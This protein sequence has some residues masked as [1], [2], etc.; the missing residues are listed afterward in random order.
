MASINEINLSKEQILD[1]Y[2]NSV[3]FGGAA[4]YLKI[5]WRSFKKQAIKLG[6]YETTKRANR[7]ANKYLLKD[8]LEGKHPQYPTSK[9]SKRLVKEG[10]KKYK[11][12][13]CFISEWNKEKI[14]LELNHIDGDS[15]NHK[16]NNLELLCP[17]CHSQTATYRSKK[18]TF[19][20]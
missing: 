8:I 10:I 17:N 7:T 3:G 18:L 12:E 16:V 11:C 19:K 4:R 2:A 13:K 14:S 20:K 15:S 6:L 9:L 5:D 1:A